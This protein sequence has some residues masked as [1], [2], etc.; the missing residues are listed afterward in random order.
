MDL[1]RNRRLT[2]VAG[3]AVATALLYALPFG[4]TLAWP[5]VLISTLAHELGHGLA[6]FLLGGRF[7]SLVINLDGSGL[8]R[9]SGA[10]GRLATATVAGAGLIGPAV[11]AFLLLVLGRRDRRAGLALGVLGAALL[12]L[13]FLRVRNAFGFWF[14][15]LIGGALLLVAIRA[16]AMAQTVIVLLAVQLGLSVFSRSDYLFTRTALTASGPH[17][18][19][20]ALMADALFLPYWF[21]GAL[22]GSLSVALLAWG[23]AIFFRR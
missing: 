22:C 20:V 18:S 10:F 21:W 4:R 6:A 7:E 16:V 1:P 9:S 17:P 8:A 11:A 2:A 23:T 13:A 12:A 5:L 3:S 15:V 19:D 14:V